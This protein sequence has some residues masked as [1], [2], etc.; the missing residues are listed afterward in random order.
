MKITVDEI[1][2]LKK[3][4]NSGYES[5]KVEFIFHSNK[6]EGSTF[7]KENLQKYLK[8][9]IIEGS[10]KVDDV[11]ETINSLELFDFV[12]E[13]LGEPISERLLFEFHRLLQKNTSNENF[14]FSGS[15]KTSG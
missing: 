14:G 2:Q 9:K 4:P 12:V 1:K 5:I 13:T 3:I 8:D 11:F 7:T 6:I 10:H 15:W